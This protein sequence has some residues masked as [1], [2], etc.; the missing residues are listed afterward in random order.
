MET[1]HIPVLPDECV[2]FLQCST[3]GGIYVDA[4]VGGGGHALRI[5]QACP[6]ISRL[7][8]IDCDR[9]AVERARQALAPY[10]EKTQ[11]L[12]GNF[13]DAEP[14]LRGAGVSAIDGILFDLGVSTHQL[15]DPRRGFSFTREGELDMRMDTALPM[16]A[17]DILKTASVDE[18]TDILKRFGEE[19]WAARIALHIKEQSKQQ[20]VTSTSRLAGIVAKA[21]PRRY[22]PAR[23]HPATK[24]F[25]AL[26]IFVNDELTSIQQGLDGVLHLLRKS[27]RIC[28]I[29]FHS[30]E[31]RIVKTT[32]NA[33]AKG[34]TCP[35]EIPRCVCGQ[36]PRVR[37]V[38]KRPVRPAE[39]ERE[40]N[41]RSRS[42]CLRVA[43]R[44]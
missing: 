32:F 4:T 18:L 29:S 12:H 30:L 40:K 34:C 42:A 3:P 11:V 21:V 39:A 38:T 26:R 36:K 6:Q 16:H 19:R 5:L 9:E 37:I 22:H 1:R 23:I 15:T 43:E 2:A 44:L 20:P 8:G 31:D 25:Q 7:I 10:A 24:T 41:P 28:V 14:L 33:W 13:R 27:G 17:G 35:P